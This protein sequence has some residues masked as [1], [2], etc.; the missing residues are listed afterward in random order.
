MRLA[1]DAVK[2]QIEIIGILLDLRKLQRAACVLDRE[3]MEVEDVVQQR[4]LVVTRGSQRSTHS[5]VVEDGSSQAGSTWSA[6][7]VAPPS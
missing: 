2:N 4:E 7:L 1:V 5:F 3:R 6:C